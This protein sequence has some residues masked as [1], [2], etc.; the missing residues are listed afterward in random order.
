MNAP[1]RPMVHSWIDESFKVNEA[2]KATKVTASSYTH[3]YSFLTFPS[4]LEGTFPVNVVA[5]DKFL[6]WSPDLQVQKA[7]YTVQLDFDE[8]VSFNA[9]VAQ[10]YIR[11]GQ[12]VAKWNVEILENDQYVEI[13]SATTIGYKRILPFDKTFTTT[14]VRMN[15][16]EVLGDTTPSITSIGLYNTIV[17]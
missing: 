17:V 16:Q 11:L 10:E 3:F 13:A 9:F 1:L 14:S 8:P 5:N 15:I 7:P 2:F 12:R 4:T 6:Y